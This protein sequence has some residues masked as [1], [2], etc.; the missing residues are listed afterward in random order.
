M[1]PSIIAAFVASF[2][3]VALAMRKREA[4]SAPSADA[5]RLYAIDEYIGN[6]EL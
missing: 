3:A 4:F 5:N 2:V 1:K 6:E